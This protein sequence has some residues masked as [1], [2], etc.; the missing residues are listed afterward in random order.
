MK[1]RD[2]YNISFRHDLAALL[3]G[4]RPPEAR[5]VTLGHDWV[6]NCSLLARIPVETRPSF[7][8]CL[9]FTVL[10]D[11]A[12]HAHFLLSYADFEKL[13]MYPKFRVG[14]GHPAYLNPI[15]IF[16][17][18]I[19]CNLVAAAEIRLLIPEAMQV[20]VAETVDFFNKHMPQIAA[21]GFFARILA[22]PEV[23]PQHESDMKPENLPL[24]HLVASELRKAVRAL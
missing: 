3:Q 1:L 16:E 17:D 23:A 9:H 10:V 4:I 13:T 20:F 5:I 11:Q 22:D 19:R 14:L 24:S 18:P 6:S 15:R 21:G 2:Y 8:A 7:L 12:M